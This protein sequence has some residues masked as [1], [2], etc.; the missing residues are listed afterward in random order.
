MPLS[1]VLLQRD[2]EASPHLQ[3]LLNAEKALRV[4]GLTH[5]VAHARQLLQSY[6]P[7][8]FI[9]DMQVQDGD[10]A[11]LLHELQRQDPPKPHVLVTTLSHDDAKL[12]RALSCGADGY[13]AHTSSAE[14]LIAS[15]KQ[16]LR[17]ESAVSPTIA[18]EILNHFMIDDGSEAVDIQ[19]L[20]LSR[21]EG[22]ILRWIAKGYLL[23]EIA[24]QWQTNLH[25]V[26]SSMR[27]VVQKIQ[28]RGALCSV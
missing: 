2:H 6:P 7:N 12:L 20:T 26:A 24:E 23:E 13:W 14:Q 28:R 15:V 17:G 25:S 5:T 22:E 18:R 9:T 10:V 1:I 11:P 27:Q 16:L 3:A 19:E 21:R 4:V 8:L